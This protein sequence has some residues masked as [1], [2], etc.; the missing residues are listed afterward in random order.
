MGNEYLCPEL[1]VWAAD[2]AI[3]HYVDPRDATV[4]K[5]VNPPSESPRGRLRDRDNRERQGKKKDREKKD[6]ERDPREFSLHITC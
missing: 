6:T 1:V 2:R 4:M 3:H 5:K